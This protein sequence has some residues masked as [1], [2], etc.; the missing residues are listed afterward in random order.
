MNRIEKINAKRRS[1]LSRSFFAR[2]TL[3][4]APDILGKVLVYESS[5]GRLAAKI[6]E[7]EAYIGEID[8]ACHAYGG[9]TRRS[10]TLFEKPATVYV[11]F[12]YGMYYC[13]NFVTEPKGIGAAVLIRAG[14]PLEGGEIMRNN[15][16]GRKESELLSGPGKFCRSFGID[17]AHNGLDLTGPTMYLEDRSLVALEPRSSSRIGIS[18]AVDLQWRFFDA[19]S[20]CLSRTVR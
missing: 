1:R 5:A 18:K 11:Y 15:S 6:V 16:P 8:P 3:E 17:L 20:N 19:A 2:P 12:I 13:L 10:Q 7:V 9:P 4:V 14:E